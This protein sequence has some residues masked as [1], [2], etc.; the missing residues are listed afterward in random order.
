M[1][2]NK[3]L[4]RAD[5]TLKKAP[6]FLR[7]LLNCLNSFCE[8]RF[9]LIDDLPGVLCAFT[10]NQSPPS[11]SLSISSFC[12]RL[13]STMIGTFAGGRFSASILS[14]SNP[15][16]PGRIRS[17]RIMMRVLGYRFF[18]LSSPSTASITVNPPLFHFCEIRSRK[19][20]RPQQGAREN[21]K[22]SL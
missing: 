20:Y 1:P 21:R 7:A 22:D 14:T 11:G 2:T 19:N 12:P 18:K 9:D 4:R 3:F 8:Y 10:N 16:A 6:A 13:E 15:S 17:R 5:T